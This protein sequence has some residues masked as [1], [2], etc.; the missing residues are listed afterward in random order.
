MTLPRHRCRATLPAELPPRYA[1]HIAS[2]WQLDQRWPRPLP[3]TSRTLVNES[4]SLAVTRVAG[5]MTI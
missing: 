3:T 5:F 4:S 2:A 1:M